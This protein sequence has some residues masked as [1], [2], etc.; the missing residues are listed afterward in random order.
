M[1]GCASTL[2]IMKYQALPVKR[3]L[4]ISCDIIGRVA[5]LIR[6][7]IIRMA[8]R[9]RVCRRWLAKTGLSVDR[10]CLEAFG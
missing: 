10:V 2:A 9:C 3:K 1:K 4:P 7:G 6:Y 8:E 5:L